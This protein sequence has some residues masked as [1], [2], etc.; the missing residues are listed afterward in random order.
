MRLVFFAAGDF[1]IPAL[2]LAAREHSVVLLVAPPAKP[3][4]RKMLVQSCPAA[5]RAKEINVAVLETANSETIC[6]QT[7]KAKPE[8]IV[9]ADY[10]ALLPPEILNIPP[11]GAINIH[12]SLLPRWR[13]AAPVVH[14]I[15]AGDSETGVCIMQMDEGLDTGNILA[16]KQMPMPEEI[17]GGELS[18]LLAKTGAMLLAEVLTT[19][20]QPSPQKKT[21]ASYAPKPEKAA[22]VL[23]FTKPAEQAARQIRAFSP[24]DPAHTII[25]GQ[26]INIHRCKF[27]KLTPP[28]SLMGGVGGGKP[29]A[30][31]QPQPGTITTADKNGIAVICGDGNAVIFLE[32][33]R[34]GKKKMPAAEFL[35]GFPLTAG[36]CAAPR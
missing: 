13:G 9:A 1:A 30:G 35:R 28:P 26:Q 10:G 31:E 7:K 34:A 4:G 21:G 33:Q 6:E 15:L 11:R 29:Q 8:A 27:N 19:N 22:R 3:R 23:D 24:A 16:R 17:T 5:A 2:E 14:S 18:A 36:D 20:P 12:P 25:N 32:M